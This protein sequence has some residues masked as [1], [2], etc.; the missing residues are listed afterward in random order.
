MFLTSI[1]INLCF[2]SLLLSRGCNVLFADLGLRPEAKTIMEQYS[3]TSSGK[4][5]AFFQ[6][7]DVTDWTHLSRMFDVAQEEFGSTDLV[8]PG[9]GVF[10]PP[11]S[12]FWNPPGSAKS[13]D[14]PEGGRYASL[15]INITHPIRVA[16][17]A[18]SA[19]LSHKNGPKAS[20]QNP[21]RILMISSVA[22]Q[23]ASLPV[24]MYHAAK[25]AVIGFTR[26]LAALDETLGIRV[27]AVAPGIIKTPLWTDNP[28]KMKYFDDSKDVWVTPEQ[29][30]E[31]MLTLVEAE[32]MVG[33]T[34]LEVG[35]KTRKVPIFNNPGPS[36]AGVV[37]TG[38]T[39]EPLEEVYKSLAEEGWGKHR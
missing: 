20:P 37:V 34:V 38:S 39:G 33:G 14:T 21:K 10:E 8:C 9:A 12:N 15:D 16:Q 32:D 2:A 28:E 13:K 27:N 35:N 17:L 19:F 5:R 6:K 31:A 22:G 30:A 1:G 7:T 24:P 3:N 18:I 4:P 29:V 26:S 36:G 11:W 25:H 23:A